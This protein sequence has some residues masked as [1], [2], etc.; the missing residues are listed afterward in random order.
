M[1]NIILFFQKY[2]VIFLFIGLQAVSMMLVFS[3]RNP[4]HHSKFANSSNAFIGEVYQSINAVNE[5]F[6]L[7]EEIEQLRLQNVA[8]KEKLSGSQ[9]VVG[10]YFTRINDTVYA[11]Q[12][13]FTPARVIHATKD[14]GQNYLTLNLGE[15][16]GVEKDMGVIGTKGVVGYIVAS[17]KHFSTVLPIIHPQFVLGVRHKRTK[18]FGLLKWEKEDS[19]STAT[20]SG[21]P[22]FIDV[23]IGDTIETTGGDG[24][25]PEGELVGVIKSTDEIKGKGE[26]KIMIDLMEDFSGEYNVFVVRNLAKSELDKLKDSTQVNE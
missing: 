2:S 17:S 9:L 12:Y 15:V 6:H 1:R 22:D 7:T 3:G 23:E 4:Y 19:W 10:N 16:N 14:K 26:L 5:Y 20:I 25:F 13:E 24:F 11:Q 8:L 21:I 18:T